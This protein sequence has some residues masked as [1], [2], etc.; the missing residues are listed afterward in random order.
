MNVFVENDFKLFLFVVFVQFFVTAPLSALAAIC[1]DPKLI[2]EPK[3]FHIQN[4]CALC[5]PAPPL[6]LS[7]FG[8]RC[9][10]AREVGSFH[11]YRAQNAVVP[12]RQRSWV[13]GSA[14]LVAPPPRGYVP[15][16]QAQTGIRGW[17]S[18]TP[19]SV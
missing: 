2:T 10:H 6:S 16:F 11:G 7:F 14:P 3:T 17:D 4:I 8:F 15:L 9:P 19:G 18:Y 13:I 12:E 1:P 5:W